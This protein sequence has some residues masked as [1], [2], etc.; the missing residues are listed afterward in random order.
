L[1]RHFT[2][3]RQQ[4]SLHTRSFEC[5]CVISRRNRFKCWNK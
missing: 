5:T 4:N 1:K 2:I 3:K